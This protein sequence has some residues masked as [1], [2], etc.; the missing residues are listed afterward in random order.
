MKFYDYRC[1][2]SDDPYCQCGSYE[3]SEH[4]LLDCPL[5]DKIRSKNL[6]Q[7]NGD[8]TRTEILQKILFAEESEHYLL[9]KVFVTLSKKAKD[10]R[11][12]LDV[13]IIR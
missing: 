1:G 4:Y 7:V 3:T 5:Y 8:E 6:P 13:Q 11:E 2:L 12:M 10:F 9:Q